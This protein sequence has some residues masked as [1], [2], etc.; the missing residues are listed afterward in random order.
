[1]NRECCGQPNPE[2]PTE[3]ECF[4]FLVGLWNC[5][6]KVKCKGDEW[7]PFTAE[8][9][10]RYI[11]DGMAIADEFRATFPDGKL[12][13]HGQNI[14]MYNPEQKAWKMK[15]IDALD[16]TVIKQGGPE[17]GGVKA[18]GSTITFH[19]LH[20]SGDVIRARYSNITDDSFEWHG[21]LLGDDGETWDEVM[22]IEARRA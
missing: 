3:L 2:A 1:M 13:M 9:F 6:G 21:A 11:L 10:G 15:W 20:D 4:S 18:N 16:A 7:K 5:A 22:V 8:W 17:L 14:R 12:F 19:I